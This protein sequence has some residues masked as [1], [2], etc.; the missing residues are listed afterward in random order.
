M[1]KPWRFFF[2][3]IALSCGVFAA[4][5]QAVA[6][7]DLDLIDFNSRLIAYQ[8]GQTPP[9][10]EQLVAKDHTEAEGV[11]VDCLNPPT[12]RPRPSA[13]PKEEAPV[14]MQKPPSFYKKPAQDATPD[15]PPTSKSFAK[16]VAAAIKKQK[17]RYEKDKGMCYRA[18]KNILEWSG[19]LT[20]K[21]RAAL[22]DP[23]KA[24]YSKH[25]SA[26]G[27]YAFDAYWDLPKYGFVNTYPNNC[28]KP[29]TVRV[30]EGDAWGMT[31]SQ[32]AAYVPKHFKGRGATAGDRAGHIEIVS[33]DGQ[34]CHF[35]C[36][37]YPMNS[38]KNPAAFGPERRI[39]KGCFVKKG[40]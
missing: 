26:P 17:K 39:L 13:T 8:L 31:R 11:C 2:F 3:A 6:D 32:A 36:N 9:G 37:A 16:A 19:L 1:R 27:D 5:L 29:L 10:Q 33:P 24:H 35:S 21:Q 7:P 4:G 15:A 25:A 38:W 14:H 40:I 30:Y 23:K 22:A 12:P 18:V 34:Y 28:N 20:S